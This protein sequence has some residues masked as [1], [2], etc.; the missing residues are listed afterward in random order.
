MLVRDFLIVFG[1][2]WLLLSWPVYHLTGSYSLLQEM[3][4]VEKWSG[5]ILFALMS[6]ICLGLAWWTHRK[7]CGC[8]QQ[9]VESWKSTYDSIVD[10]YDSICDS[11]TKKPTSSYVSTEEWLN[12]WKKHEYTHP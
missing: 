1:L 4:L 3:S 6:L 9:T 7:E 2:V 8:D 11:K 12:K 10:E 5:A